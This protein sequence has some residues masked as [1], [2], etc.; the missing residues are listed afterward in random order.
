MSEQVFTADSPEDGCFWRVLEPAE[1]E[2]FRN[3]PGTYGLEKFSF[4]N[5]NGMKE[6]LACTRVKD[7][8]CVRM[9]VSRSK[10]SPWA[11]RGGAYLLVAKDQLGENEW[12]VVAGK[13]DVYVVG[14]AAVR[15]GRLEIIP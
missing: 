10:V 7:R 6:L 4:D 13:P 5:R 11:R 8:R 1:L 9:Q 15:A 2:I 3:S 12:E 14:A